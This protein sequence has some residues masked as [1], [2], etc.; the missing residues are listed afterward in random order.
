MGDL[1]SI[2]GRSALVLVALAGPASAQGSVSGQ[3]S[4]LERPGERTDDLADV[5]VWLEPTS[6]TR[7]RILPKVGHVAM[8][9]APQRVVADYLDFLGPRNDA[10]PRAMPNWGD[11]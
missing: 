2:V 5:I 11:A 3:V 1:I 7:V 9:E 4:L 8:V 10:E 6:G